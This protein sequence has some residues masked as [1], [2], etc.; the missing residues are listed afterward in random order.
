[1]VTSTSPALYVSQNGYTFMLEWDVKD[2][3]Q[4]SGRGSSLPCVFLSD[5]FVGQSVHFIRDGGA[6]KSV[7]SLTAPGL[8]FGVSFD[9]D[10]S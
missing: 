3:F 1:M 4:V 8:Y 7:V 5:G 10:Q 9:K 2:V 6:G